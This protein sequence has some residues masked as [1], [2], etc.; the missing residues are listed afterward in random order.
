MARTTW[1]PLS[2]DEQNSIE[3]APVGEPGELAPGTAGG[4]LKRNADGT[5][6]NS[7]LSES[8]SVLT[9][10]GRLAINGGTVT[11]STPVIDATQTWN[12]GAV[13]FTGIK[14]NIPT[15]TFASASLLLDLQYAGVS[16]FNVNTAGSVFVKTSYR[17]RS[18]TGYFSLGTGDD[19]LLQ[20]G[21]ANTLDLRSGANAQ[22]FQVY[23][24]TDA[25]L[26]N[27]RRIRTT[28]TTG[29]AATIAAEGFG[30][31]WSANT[32]AL[33]VNAVTA[34]SFS[35]SGTASFSGTV[36]AGGGV[37]SRGHQGRPCNLL[38]MV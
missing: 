18:N 8:G 1:G 24:T 38:W 14:L 12:D 26:L 10:L 4:L 16:Q 2:T 17:V 25:G 32:L 34:L 3:F 13:T 15:S 33:V 19:V 7:I 36:Y 11:A 30:A 22:T 6:G 37:S 20:R 31:G 23:G 9:L 5:M 29:G 27:Y 21:A 28:M 35:A